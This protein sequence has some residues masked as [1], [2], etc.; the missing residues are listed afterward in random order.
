MSEALRFLLDAGLP[1]SAVEHLR[2]DG[3]DVV[4]VGDRG[5]ANAADADVL[6]LAVNEGRVVVTLDADFHA[7]LAL[8][9]EARPSVIRLRVE[10]L[11]GAALAALLRAVVGA[12]AD[13][14]VAGAVVTADST[15]VRLRRLPLSR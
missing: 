9:G 13:D 15:R 8:S 5:M 14:L 1:R 3:L 11:R 2:R 6:A 4:H 12:C 10:G 7:L